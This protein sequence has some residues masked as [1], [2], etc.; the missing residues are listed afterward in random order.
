MENSTLASRNTFVV[1]IFYLSFSDEEI[2]KYINLA[3]K[4][5][6]EGDQKKRFILV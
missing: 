4:R 5:K 6:L 1:K 2:A 3:F